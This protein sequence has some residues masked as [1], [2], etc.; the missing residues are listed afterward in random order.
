MN[1]FPC[2][3]EVFPSHASSKQKK[4]GPQPF[5]APHHDPDQHNPELQLFSAPHRDPSL[6]QSPISSVHYHI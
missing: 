3:M 2:Q 5:S 6:V 1:P 4:T